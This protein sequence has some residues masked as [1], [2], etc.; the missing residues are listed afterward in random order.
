MSKHTHIHYTIE[1]KQQTNVV[2]KEN[3]RLEVIV[4]NSFI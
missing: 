1:R 3:E 4:Y 2:T